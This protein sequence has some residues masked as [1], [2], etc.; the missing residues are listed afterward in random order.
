MNSL[1]L[2]TA[3]NVTES[4]TILYNKIYL[5]KYLE[6]VQYGDYVD[7]VV[8]DSICELLLK[9]YYNVFEAQVGE[10][11][12]SII[13]VR[14]NWSDNEDG[15]T[16]LYAYVIAQFADEVY[17]VLTGNLNKSSLKDIRSELE[18]VYNK[19][20]LISSVVEGQ[21]EEYD[22]FYGVNISRFYNLCKQI[23]SSKKSDTLGGS[24]IFK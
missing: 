4:D 8:L 2:D 13:S 24:S 17:S 22:S 1:K 5:E 12:H 14:Y 10:L 3:V 11:R 18:E 15:F 16:L 6:M 20:E 21:I 19:H 9:L 23:A 7:G